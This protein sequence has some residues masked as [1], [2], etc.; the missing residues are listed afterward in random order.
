MC[1]RRRFL[2]FMPSAILSS[3]LVPGMVLADQSPPAPAP[4]HEFPSQDATKVLAVVGASHRN[5]AKVKELVTASPAL[6][7]CAWDWGYGDW[8]TPL[9]AASHVGQPQIAEYLMEHGARPDIFTFAMLGDLAAVKAIVG[10]HPGIQKT[11]GPHGITLMTHASNGGDRAVA[12]VDYLTKLGGADEAL[13][14]K[15]LTNEDMAVYIGTYG[16]GPGK[17]DQ[18]EVSKNAQGILTIKRGTRSPSILFCVEENGF[19]PSGS[20]HVR[21]RFQLKAGKAESVTVHDPG[22]IIV[23]HRV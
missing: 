4:Y 22:P 18:L 8:E 1:S 12:V 10:A 23:A 17:D 3:S 13:K 16:F 21:I 14:S 2:G 9:G 20:P 5:L 19:F 7:K 15:A 6:A 11:L